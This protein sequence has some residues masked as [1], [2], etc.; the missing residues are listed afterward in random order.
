MLRITREEKEHNRL[1]ELREGKGAAPSSPFPEPGIVEGRVSCSVASDS[2]IPRTV[3]HQVPL[4]R[5][6]SGQECWCG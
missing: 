6:F 3:A 5:R 1:R 4:S 2:A